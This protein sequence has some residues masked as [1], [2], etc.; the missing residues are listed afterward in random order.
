MEPQDFSNAVYIKQREIDGKWAIF[1]TEDDTEALPG[2]WWATEEYADAF[3]G[4][5]KGALNHNQWNPDDIISPD[6]YRSRLFHKR[7]KTK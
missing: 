1:K 7:R 2:T 6:E 5:I 4:Y 3:M